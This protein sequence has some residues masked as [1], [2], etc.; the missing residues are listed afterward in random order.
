MKKETL[1]TFFDNFNGEMEE[2]RINI[3]KIDGYLQKASGLI[4]D[5]LENTFSKSSGKPRKFQNPYLYYRI[6]VKNISS[7]GSISEEIKELLTDPI[8]EISIGDGINTEHYMVYHMSSVTEEDSNSYL[9][10]KI[11]SSRD[12]TTAIELINIKDLAVISFSEREESF[13]VC[14]FINNSLNLSDFAPLVEGRFYYDSLIFIPVE[15]R[16]PF[17]SIIIEEQ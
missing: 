9:L 13:E 12:G 10:I 15:S 1:D 2:H 11:V 16:S 5:G 4:K 17:D 6:D 3:V 8:D 14:Y 7:I